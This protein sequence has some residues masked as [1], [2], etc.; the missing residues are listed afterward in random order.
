LIKNKWFK[1]GTFCFCWS[2]LECLP[3]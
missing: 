2:S 1:K 3:G